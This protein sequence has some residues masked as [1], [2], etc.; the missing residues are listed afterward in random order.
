MKFQS[1]PEFEIIANLRYNHP[2]LFIN[3]LKS[4]FAKAAFFI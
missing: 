4:Q 2:Q 1:G 3:Q